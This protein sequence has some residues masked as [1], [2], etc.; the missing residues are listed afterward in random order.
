MESVPSVDKA[1]FYDFV[2][3]WMDRGS[4]LNEFDLAVDVL[5]GTGALIQTWDFK[6]CEITGYGTYLHDTTFIYSY[7]GLQDSEI[8]DRAN[9]SC[10]GVSLKTP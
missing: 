7:S 6:T 3:D 4:L 2:A 1:P 10:V 5:D 8:R 9:F